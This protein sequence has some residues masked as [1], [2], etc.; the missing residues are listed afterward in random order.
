MGVFAMGKILL[1]AIC[2][3][4][5]LISHAN[6][7]NKKT[8]KSFK[9]G[10]DRFLK[11]RGDREDR[12]NAAKAERYKLFEKNE[13]RMRDMQKSRKMKFR[14]DDR[15]VFLF[16]SDDEKRQYLGL[17]N[18]TQLDTDLDTESPRPRGGRPRVP[19]ERSRVRQHAAKRRPA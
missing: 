10:Y 16:M 18:V 3:V 13:K 1:V 9:K 8:L 19:R 15:S 12:S 6:A 5:L 4:I 2:I 14:F 7:S 11:H 17:R